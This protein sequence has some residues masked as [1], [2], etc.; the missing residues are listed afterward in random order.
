M[1]DLNIKN[2]L[3]HWQTY[4]AFK[5]AQQDILKHELANMGVEIP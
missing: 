4:R 5:C 3:K 1:L 2:R